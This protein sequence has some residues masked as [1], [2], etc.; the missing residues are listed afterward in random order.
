[1]RKELVF[2][3]IARSF[4]SLSPLPSLPISSAMNAYILVLSGKRT[5]EDVNSTLVGVNSLLNPLQVLLSASFF[6]PP[7]SSLLSPLSSLLPS[8]V[9]EYREV[10][11]LSP[12]RCVFH[13]RFSSREKLCRFHASL[14]SWVRVSRYYSLT[15][16]LCSLDVSG[17]RYMAHT[18]RRERRE[19]REKDRERRGRERERGR[20]GERSAL[21]SSSPR[22]HHHH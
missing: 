13:R 12:H 6:V 8:R 22:S 10:F 9:T 14:R 20:E 21:T 19:K 11:L 7:P 18:Q 5:L 3:F 4:S 1:M 17:L 2:T 15:F 16:V